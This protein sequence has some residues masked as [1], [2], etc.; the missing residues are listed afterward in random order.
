MRL[1]T[2]L[3]AFPPFTTENT[4]KIA[5]S[6]GEGGHDQVGT[7]TRFCEHDAANLR[8]MRVMRQCAV[9]LL[10]LTLAGCGGSP[11][12]PTPPPPPAT[13]TGAVTNTVTGAPISGFTATIANSRL[14]VSAPGYVTRET[15]A[16]ASTVDLIPEAGFDLG[17][18]RQ[19]ARDANE[20]SSLQSLAV[21]S[22]SPSIYLQ[23]SGLSDSNAAVLEA[24]ARDTLPAMTGGRLT[25]AAFESGTAAR[26]DQS[27]WIVAEVIDDAE[28]PCGRGNVGASAGHVWLNAAT[29]C[30]Y[31]GNRVDPSVFA[32]ELGHAIGFY[33][34]TATGALMSL[35]HAYGSVVI[36]AAERHHGA[37]AY[38][39]PRGNRDVDAD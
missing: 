20:S 16:S 23:R 25:V 21:L 6:Y 2:S 13:F 5:R 11:T 12:A 37:I 30:N 3:R 9:L 24:A 8:I 34:V 39:R 32:H 28:Q 35:T 33:H 38:K 22:A 10:L 26:A 36:T 14:T 31:L 4:R 1:A 18:Y 29:K 27:G 19:F 7:E 17:F 15:S